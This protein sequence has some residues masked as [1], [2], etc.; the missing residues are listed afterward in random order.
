MPKHFDEENSGYLARISCFFSAENPD[1]FPSIAGALLV[2]TEPIIWISKSY[3]AKKSFTHWKTA[4]PFVVAFRSSQEIF[5]YD[6]I[7]M[8]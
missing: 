8:S 5:H 7:Q 2:H 4:F 3:F 6:T 1:L